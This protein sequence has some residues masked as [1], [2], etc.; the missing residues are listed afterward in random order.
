MAQARGIKWKWMTLIVSPALAMMWGCAAANPEM[1]GRAPSNGWL[2]NAVYD[3][4]IRNAIIAQRAIFPYHFELDAPTL[5]EL[6]RR[7]LAVLTA[8]FQTRPGQLSVRRG[9]VAPELYDR[10]V[11]TVLD[12]LVVAG[13]D[14]ARITISDTPARGDGLPSEQVLHILKQTSKPAT[15]PSTGG[16]EAKT[17][18]GAGSKS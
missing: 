14:E 9:D 16:R 6:G 5:H 4:A 12:A 7:D 10:R 18:T 13:V 1:S 17:V 3:A 15:T 8:H 11:R 2:A